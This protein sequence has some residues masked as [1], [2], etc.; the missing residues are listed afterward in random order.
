LITAS[1]SASMSAAPWQAC[2]F[3]FLNFMDFLHE[4]YPH[5]VVL[6]T[7][8]RGGSMPEAREHG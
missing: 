5:V 6:G 7:A 1:I 4:I 3:S 2:S 8:T